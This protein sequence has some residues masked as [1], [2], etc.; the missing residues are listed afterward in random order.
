MKEELVFVKANYI[1]RKFKT[2]KEYTDLDK[3]K[4]LKAIEHKIYIVPAQGGCVKNNKKIVCSF[5]TFRIIGENK[6]MTN[7]L[8]SKQLSFVAEIPITRGDVKN[9]LGDTIFLSAL[10][11]YVKTILTPQELRKTFLQTSGVINHDGL[12]GVHYTILIP[13][14]L[15]KVLKKSQFP[16]GK[17]YRISTLDGHSMDT[18]SQ[19]C[20]A[21]YREVDTD[22]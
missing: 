3:R 16:S 11:T 15:E 14:E 20:L 1:D 12:F 7:T 13:K 4:L 10:T 17:S 22:E 5:L 2:L 18:L 19:M 9:N 8:E 21:H 6:L